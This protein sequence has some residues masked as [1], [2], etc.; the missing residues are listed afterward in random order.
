MKNINNKRS[1]IISLII[2]CDIIAIG[3]GVYYFKPSA[4]IS[5]VLIYFIPL[6]VLINFIIAGIMCFVQK[7]Y[8]T[9]FMYNAILSTIILCVFFALFSEINLK[10][11]Y[12]KWDF[13]IDKI[14]YEISYWPLLNN[15]YRINTNLGKGSY[16]GCDRGVVTIQ[17][18]TVYFFSIDSTHFYI[19][20]NWLY[21]FNGIEKIRVKKI[22]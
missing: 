8:A 20:K 6:V 4:D 10:K 12:E 22:Y 21:N 13:R 1:L 16:Q 17:N 15:D 7:Y 14:N 3:S 11:E 18:D 9:L 19:Y 5:I 2:L